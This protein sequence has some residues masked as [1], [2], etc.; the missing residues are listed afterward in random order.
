MSRIHVSV[1]YPDFGDSER[2]EIWDAFFRKLEREREKEVVVGD[3][4]RTYVKD[5]REVRAV[6]WN[7]REIRNGT[8]PLSVSLFPFI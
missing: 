8:C 5:S 7:G 2:M 4:A 1:H 6:K 3:S